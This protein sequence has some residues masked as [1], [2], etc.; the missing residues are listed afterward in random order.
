MSQNFVDLILGADT[1]GLLKGKKALEETTVAGAKAEKAV[2]GTEKG[3]KKAGDGASQAKP[4]IDGFNS[5]ADRSKALALGATKALVGLA[6]S[7]AT[8]A[9]VGASIRLARDFNAALAETST[10]IDG[11]P[12]EL[13]AV[14]KAARGMSKEFGST[15]TAQVKAFYQALSAG[16][17]GVAGATALLDQ[18]NKLA[19]GGVTDVTT[20]VDALTTAMNAYGADVLSAADASDAMFVAMRAGKTTIGELAGSLGRIVPIASAAGVSFDEVTAGI[21]ALTTQGLS[22]SSATT[23]LRQVIAAVI[24]PTKE[25]T[26]A[27]KAL[28]IEF[29]VQALKAQGLAGFLDNVIT[30]TGGNEAAMAQLFGSVEALGAVLAFAGGAGGTFS[31]ILEDM[32][33][34]AGATDAAYQKMSESLDQRW[35]KLTAAATDIAL[36]FGNAL[37]AVVVPAMEGIAAV[38][39]MVGQN[40]DV[41]V[42]AISALAATQIPA[43]IAGF[44]ALTA[45]MSASAVAT[46][47]FTTALTVARAAL[48]ALGG[49]IGLIYGILGASAAAWLVWSNGADDGKQASYDA[50]A[51]TS[52]LLGQLDEFYMTSAPSAGAA[53]I[54]L[55]NDNYKLAASAFEAAKGELAK[56]RAMLDQVG[57]TTGL[58]PRSS[59]SATQAITSQIEKQ[60]L[61]L[62]AAEDALAQSI[63]DRKVAANAVTGSASELIASNKAATDSTRTLNVSVDGLGDA[64]KGA[65][66]AMKDASKEVENFADEIE[67]LEFDADP[68]KKYNAE[69]AELN[70]IMATGDLPSG[71][72]EKAVADL[73]EEFANSNPNISKIGDAIGD[74]VAGGMRDF[75]SLLDSF[76]NMIKQMIATAIANPIK[77]ALSAALGGG[78]TAA[79]AGQLGGAPGG[80]GILGGLGGISTGV[81]NFIGTLGGGSGILGGIGT[82]GG[83]FLNGGLGA[84]VSAI[85]STLGGVS[86]GLGGL[87]A[88][89]GAVALPIAAVAA[90]FSFFKKK[91]EVLDS[92]FRL[93][94]DG[95]DLTLSSFEKVKTSRFWGLSKKVSM[96]LKE[97]DEATAGPLT[98]SINAIQNGIFEQATALGTAADTFDAFTTSI[99]ASTA[100]LSEADAQA[101]ISEVL[102]TFAHRFAGMVPV[103]SSVMLEGEQF[104]ETL[105]RISTAITAF[106]GVADALGF[107]LKDMSIQGGAAASAFIEARG[108]MGAFIAKTNAYYQL[109]YS[110]QERVAK[111]TDNMRTALA[112]LGLIMPATIEGFRALVEQAERMGNMDRVGSLIDLSGAFAGLLDGQSALRDTAAADLQAAFAREMEATR[113]SF[114]IAIAGLQN[115]LTGARERLASSRAIASALESA[116]RSRIFP[117]VDAQRLSQDRAAAYL[118]TLV[119]LDRINDVGALQDALSAVADPSADTYSTLEDYRSDFNRTSGVIADLEKTAGFALSADEQAVSLLEQQIADMQLQSDQA[120]SLLQQQLDALLGISTSIM[121]LADAISAFAAAVTT[122]DAGAGGGTSGLGPIEQIYQDVLGRSA[123]A[124]GLAWYRNNLQNGNSSIDQIRNNISASSEAAN[125]ASTGIPKFASGGSHFGGLRIV[126]ERGPELEVTGPSRIFNATQTR[127]MMRGGSDNSE[128]VAELR[129][130]RDEV[131][132]LKQVN[133]STARSSN[134]TAMVAEKWDNI[135]IPGTAEGEVIKTEAV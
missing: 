34:K 112:D 118:S 17:D 68:L 19:I 35:N 6:A 50:A 20:G 55:A 30:K 122:V 77:L 92:G 84:G 103:L 132:E 116:L 23:G 41:V 27:A 12:E 3:F 85:G 89:I 133:M 45:G 2:S 108:G 90:A 22:T 134:K 102:E 78:G 9:A 120:V 94:A 64:S 53:A 123:D 57:V 127:N 47:V 83:A 73:N 31:A 62:A 91:T 60:T 7:Y 126:G 71:A 72:Y 4:K 114:Q 38:S 80:G 70:K 65:G 110:D 13:E 111:S 130:L 29:D 33:T 119:G 125:F 18:A 107:S 106:N 61:K 54:A 11:T 96:N 58:D 25:A 8:F 113:A 32:T 36:G 128:M 135:G 44:V 88:A 86:A 100:G 66:K 1:R 124:E 59:R 104:H 97:M 79:A 26:D 109:F 43:A 28:G 15:A 76:K 24:K 121:S 131:A 10:L 67:R 69:L 49:P 21:A 129:K 82:V 99:D 14:T 87:G 52:A 98:K 81:G 16:A 117:S 5:A 93:M 75:G 56:R 42:I 105:N 115:E 95:M 48:I 37:L 40:L 74:F 46:G 51:G 39:I 101:K 63:R